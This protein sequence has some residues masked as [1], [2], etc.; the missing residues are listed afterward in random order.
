MS[1]HCILFLHI[2]LTEITFFWNKWHVCVLGLRNEK[3]PCRI[4]PP[5]LEGLLFHGFVVV[6]YVHPLSM[7]RESQLLE[8]KGREPTQM[9]EIMSEKGR[10][11]LWISLCHKCFCRGT[12]RHVL[13]SERMQILVASVRDLCVASLVTDSPPE[14][15]KH[16][17]QT[18]FCSNNGQTRRES[19]RVIL[20]K[21]CTT[22]VCRPPLQ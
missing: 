8:D 13:S 19:A 9:K 4:Y 16:R 10:F 14:V 11:V 6:P 3:Q 17:I 18:L 22:C 5:C 20:R 2:C 1:A 12:R 15:G 21:L 7:D